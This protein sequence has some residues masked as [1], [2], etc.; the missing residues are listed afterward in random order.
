M[1]NKQTE[2][3]VKAPFSNAKTTLLI[4]ILAIAVAMA[5]IGISVFSQNKPGLFLSEPVNGIKEGL[6]D[7]IN[8]IQGQ[9]S[10][11]STRLK[12]LEQQIR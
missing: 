10:D 6:Q 9:V 3:F 12:Q 5:M 1:K 11:L 7:Q 2:S 4:L 8:D